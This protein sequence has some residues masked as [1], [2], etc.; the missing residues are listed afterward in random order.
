[1]AECSRNPA[2]V[3]YTKGVSMGGDLTAAP[4]GK[5]PTFLIAAL[6]DPI[7]ANLDRI[8]IVKGWQAANGDLKEKVQAK[9][10]RRW[11]GA[12]GW[13]HR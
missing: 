6:K 4:A 8:Q 12:A 2:E 7:G 11:Q 3:G 5:V 13:Q 9:A 10:R 1:M